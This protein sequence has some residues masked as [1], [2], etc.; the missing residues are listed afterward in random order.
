MTPLQAEAELFDVTQGHPG[1]RILLVP[2]F[3]EAVSPRLRPGFRRF[4]V[5]TAA[6]TSKPVE[7]LVLPGAV[8]HLPIE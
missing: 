3:E 7:V 8:V 2:H 5:R 1:E 6:S 4:V